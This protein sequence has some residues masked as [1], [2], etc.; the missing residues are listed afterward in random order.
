MNFDLWFID[1][2]NDYEIC[3]FYG[4]KNMYSPE[5][6]WEVSKSSLITMIFYKWKGT[7][8]YLQMFLGIFDLPPSRYFDVIYKQRTLFKK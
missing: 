2:L 1:T 3:I 5:S 7:F 4:D 6:F 8:T